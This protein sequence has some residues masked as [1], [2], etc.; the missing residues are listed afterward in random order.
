MTTEAETLTLLKTHMKEAMRAKERERLGTIRMVLASLKNK[1][2]EL[3]RELDEADILTVLSTEAKRRREAADAYRDGGRD[4]LADKEE[5]ELLVLATYLPEPMNDDDVLAIIDEAIAST[6][7]QTRRDMGR[8][9]GVLMP[10]IKGR[11]DGKRAKDLVLE[12]LS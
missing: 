3:R 10:R 12:K 5:A 2:I 11:F 6:G 8:I 4:E 9:I 1:Q 7:A